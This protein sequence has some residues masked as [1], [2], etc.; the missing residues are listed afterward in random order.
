MANEKVDNFPDITFRAQDDSSAGV[1]LVPLSSIY[2]RAPKLN[3]NPFEAHRVHFHQLICIS[4]G[5][6][7]HFI[8]FHDY[9]VSAGDFVFINKNQIH[10]FDQ[11][12]RPLGVSLMFTQSFIESIHANV[13][14]PAFGA[15]YQADAA[16]PVFRPDA[17]TRERC[18]VLLSE[19][20]QTSETEPGGALV[21]QLL[22]A[23]VL[24]TLHSRRPN[25]RSDAFSEA[26]RQRF[27]TFMSLVET[28]YVTRQDAAFYADKLSMTYK[29]LNDLTK[30]L[31]A[32]TPKQ[33]ID[34]HR[35]LEAKRRLTID[36]IQISKLAYELGFDDVSNFNKYFKKH[37]AVTPTQF[38]QSMWG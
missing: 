17:A 7:N 37:T 32:K 12:N 27:S 36:Q 22:F 38:Q 8:D 10:A 33:L 13:R 1:D 34:A 15:G 14:L 3:H 16:A 25:G 26:D 20:R 19:I 28:H 23:A 18:E 31:C 6:G 11:A 29:T 35:V 9:P 21:I 4:E 2:E 5:A 24:V 30:R